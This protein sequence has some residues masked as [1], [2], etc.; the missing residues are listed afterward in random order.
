MSKLYSTGINANGLKQSPKGNWIF[1]K[2]A[3]YI[4]KEHPRVRW[5]NVLTCGRHSR[6]TTQYW[7]V[8]WCYLYK[9][10]TWKLFLLE[11]QDDVHY[12]WQ[13]VKFLYFLK[14]FCLLGFFGVCFLMLEGWRE[15]IYPFP[16]DGTGSHSNIAALK[17]LRARS[18]N[19]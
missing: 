8:L 6:I 7:W 5:N 18:T 10:H 19:C 1:C 11:V 13:Q 14:G 16:S 4:P 12:L 9:S 17:P 15:R 3:L 2:S